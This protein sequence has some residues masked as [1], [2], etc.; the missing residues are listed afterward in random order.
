MIY[1]GRLPAT[2]HTPGHIEQPSMLETKDNTPTAP[3]D[4]RMALPL[5]PYRP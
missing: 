3:I 1:F 4:L 5:H 2:E